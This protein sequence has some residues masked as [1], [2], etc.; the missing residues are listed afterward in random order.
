MFFWQLESTVR[1]LLELEPGSDP[2]W[3]YLTIQVCNL[4]YFF[5]F[6]SYCVL[7]QLSI[8]LLCRACTSRNFWRAA[9][10]NIVKEWR[11][12]EKSFQRRQNWMHDGKNFKES[13]TKQYEILWFLISFRNNRHML[14]F[15]FPIT[16]WSRLLLEFWRTRKRISQWR[17]W[18][19]Y[20]STI[21]Y[22]NQQAYSS[23]NHSAGA[24]SAL[25]LAFSNGDI[26]R[27]IWKSMWRHPSCWLLMIAF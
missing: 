3:H 20:D 24:V 18:K 26:Q 5:E 1:L 11:K 8:Y 19:S 9:L 2:I 4:L 7:L 13:Q 12:W 6:I 10:W 22:T 21:R 17:H 25:I 15:L 14:M 23:L 27:E 16:V